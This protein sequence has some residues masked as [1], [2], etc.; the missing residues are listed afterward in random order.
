MVPIFEK[1]FAPVLGLDPEMPC[2]I[3]KVRALPAGIGSDHD[4]YVAR[5]VPGFFWGQ[6][7]RAVYRNTH[8]TQ[9][10]VFSAAIPEYQVHTSIVVAIGAYGVANWPEML[11][12][13][14]PG[15]ESQP[16]P[17]R[18]P[19]RLGVQMA[20]AGLKITGFNATSR[21]KDAGF[22]VGDLIVETDGVKVAT[23][24]EFADGINSGGDDKKVRV[25]RDGKE[26]VLEVKFPPR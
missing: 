6:K 26:I 21:A 5:G 10:D 25:V 9:N 23:T 16:N 13:P 3:R 19:R 24:G 12:R 4:S 7:G 15:P 22:L 1:V 20:E 8:H 17:L 14:A 18:N 2:E 11:P